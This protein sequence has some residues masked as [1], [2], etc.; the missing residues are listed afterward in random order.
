MF[1]TAFSPSQ[2]GR[3]SRRLYET[4]ESDI[5]RIFQNN[6]WTDFQRWQNVCD[7]IFDRPFNFQIFAGVE[8]SENK[9]GA[10]FKSFT[11]VENMIF[12]DFFK[13]FYYSE[14]D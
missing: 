11:Y 8:N 3:H 2:D 12:F 6:D 9:F 13:E 10:N 7:A 1:Y 4:D 14:N 5:Q